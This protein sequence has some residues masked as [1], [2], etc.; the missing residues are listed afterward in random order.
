[1]I[2]ISDLDEIPNLENLNFNIV[3]DNIII[4]EQKI[5]YY[6]LNLIYDDFL[7]QGTKICKKKNFLSPQ[8]LRNIKG[9]K[10]SKMENRY[11]FSKKNII[12][13]IL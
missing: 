9:K 5:L 2:L 12:I 7:W 8:W 10:L 6:K 1:M 3:K 11:F 13:L 4:F